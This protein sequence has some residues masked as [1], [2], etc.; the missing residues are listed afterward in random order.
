[1]KLGF[2]EQYVLNKPSRFKVELAS[3]K[4][5]QRFGL[6]SLEVSAECSPIGLCQAAQP[7]HY[8]MCCLVLCWLFVSV[9]LMGHVWREQNNE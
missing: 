1:M 4:L 3:G 5:G 2:W 6:I 9:F 8:Q 7:L